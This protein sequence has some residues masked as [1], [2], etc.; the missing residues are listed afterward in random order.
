MTKIE[1]VEFFKP[2]NIALGLKFK[3]PKY[4]ALFLNFEPNSTLIRFCPY[5]GKFLIILD[6]IASS[7]NVMMTYIFTL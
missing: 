1:V 3:N 5:E 4:N 2:Y 6:L 7:G